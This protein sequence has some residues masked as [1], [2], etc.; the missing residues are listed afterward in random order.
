MSV[1]DNP[2]GLSVVDS[3]LVDSPFVAQLNVGTSYPF[4]SDDSLLTEGGVFIL[5]EG[6]DFLTTE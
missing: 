5:T 3:P 2:L 4:T 6:G 1:W